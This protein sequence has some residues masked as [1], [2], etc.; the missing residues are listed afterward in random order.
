MNWTTL[1]AH[2][3]YLRYDNVY[4]DQDYSRYPGSSR[5]PRTSAS[6]KGSICRFASAEA[7][8]LFLE[9]A[10]FFNVTSN[11]QRSALVTMSYSGNSRCIIKNTTSSVILSES[12]CK[13]R[14][15]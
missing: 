2:K 13:L 10:A 14:E 12:L 9:L 5:E 8:M 15:G 11:L 3:F 1:S 6:P 7:F 4:D